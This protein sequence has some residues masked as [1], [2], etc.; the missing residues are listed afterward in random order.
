M[1]DGVDPGANRS[2][3]T[4][5]AVG[6]SNHLQTRLLGLVDDCGELVVAEDPDARIG[7]GN[8]ARSV[9]KILMRS[10]PRPATART[11]RRRASV[12][13]TPRRRSANCGKSMKN[14]SAGRGL[15]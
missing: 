5:I 4:F 1:L 2:S 3:S 8:P 10:T 7:V 12:P 13:C 14:S 15:I 11:I 6:V 9:D